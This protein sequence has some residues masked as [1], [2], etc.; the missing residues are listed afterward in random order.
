MVKNFRD[1]GEWV[2][3][4]AGQPLLPLGRVFRSGKLDEISSLDEVG[5]PGTILNLRPL[6]D[7][8]VLDGMGVEGRTV[9]RWHAACEDSPERYD[10]ANP[11]V[12]K[13]LVGI[14]QTLA[15]DSIPFPL[16]VHCRS[17]KDRTGVVIAALL[18]L[19]EVPRRFIV[20]EYFLSEGEVRREWIEMALFG[21]GN[22]VEYFAGVNVKA[23]RQRILDTTAD[24]LPQRRQ[25]MRIAVFG[26]TH[27]H[28]ELMYAIVAHEQQ[29]S[30]QP[31]DLILQV[32]D[33]GAF[34]NSENVDDATRRA[35]ELDA[36]ELGFADFVQED[37]P[38]IPR[39]PRRPPTVFIPGNH[40]DFEYLRK[41]SQATAGQPTYPITPDGTIR[42]LRA[43]CVLQFF[44]GGRTVRIAGVSGVTGRDRHDDRLHAD[45]HLKME[46]VGSLMKHGQKA[47]DILLTHDGPLGIA[48][49][50]EKGQWHD[51]G[52]PVLAKFIQNCQPCLAFFGHYET[53]GQGKMGDTLVTCLNEC[54]YRKFGS[55]QVT[56]HCVAVVE[57]TE[58]LPP[59]VKRLEWLPTWTRNNW[60][61]GK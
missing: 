60:R 28:L 10:T 37:P 20:E 16:L 43:G 33:L 24:G 36:E 47:C 58:E 11:A 42:A 48:K 38:L 50:E 52:T 39:L 7:D 15:N 3:E 34:P 2:N 21:L 54:C 18:S 57:W 59:E 31:I 23:I 40:E 4:L 12:K 5:R 35:A 61:E 44:T 32:G 51:V 46:D 17:G 49:K 53:E 22:P 55:W 45:I 19:L 8:A 9:K 41:C 30:G 26:D 1:V 6:V 14:F 13:W 56:P 27:G 29:Q 25:P